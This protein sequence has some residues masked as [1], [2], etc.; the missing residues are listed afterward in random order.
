MRQLRT[1]SNILPLLAALFLL[2]LL[3]RPAMAA[4][5]VPASPT[6][7]DARA[8]GR[9]PIRITFVNPGRADEV[10]WAMV[11]DSMKEAGR[12]LGFS[13]EVL[14]AER[15]RQ[16]MVRL[17]NEV[18]ARPQ[19]PD[20]LILVNEESAATALVV[21]ADAAGI[22]V[23]M[24]AS[25]FSGE[26]AQ[27]FG[28]PRT[29]LRHWIGSLIPDIGAAGGRMGEALVKHARTQATRGP[30]GRIHLLAL[31]GDEL[32]PVSVA[33]NDGLRN[34]VAGQS[35]VVIDRFLFAHWN[36]ADAETAAGRYFDW[37]KSRG[38]TVQGIWAA[39]DPMALGVIAAAQARGLQAGR[40]FGLVGL[41][42]SPE[43]IARVRDGQMLLTDG[44]HFMLGA[45]SVVMLRDYFDGCD[46]ARTSAAQVMPTAAYDAS[47]PPALD[48][49]IA[50]RDFARIDFKRFRA[51]REH[52]G[53]YEF[54]P[55]RLVEA[56]QP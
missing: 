53:R 51:T 18:I 21:A 2:A 27:H 26:D 43:A 32:T 42:W 8:H 10:Y 39:N 14:F 54:S 23:L 6:A 15:N 40:D 35:D 3:C 48:R 33:R 20:V 7:S 37:M 12:Q 16:T 44:G 50:T 17:G 24:L 1:R 29:K 52:C 47:V 45:W 56:L 5:M 25:A 31:G 46:F 19:P 22:R 4:P 11:A 30:D 9:D 38:A 28:A 41:N 36:K 34:Y 13:V 55:A 49:L